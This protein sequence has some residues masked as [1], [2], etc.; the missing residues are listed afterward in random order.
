MGSFAWGFLAAFAAWVRSQATR[1]LGNM[2]RTRQFLL[3]V[4]QA[5]RW[6]GRQGSRAGRGLQASWPTRAE[7][8][9]ARWGASACSSSPSAR[10]SI[11]LGVQSVFLKSQSGGTSCMA[12]RPSFSSFSPWRRYPSE[13]SQIFPKFCPFTSGNVAV[14]RRGSRRTW[15]GRATRA[16]RGGRVLTAWA[17]GRAAMAG[18]LPLRHWG[19]GGSKS[20]A[21]IGPRGGSGGVEATNDSA[22]RLSCSAKCFCFGWLSPNSRPPRQAR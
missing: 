17:G 7:P 13:V 19:L 6:A 21:N 5:L 8:P 16:W 22:F 9:S 11:A 3:V 1:Q 18:G 4:V 15:G 12:C 10:G 14:A 20:H 2:V